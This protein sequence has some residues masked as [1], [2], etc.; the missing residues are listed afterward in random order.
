[1]LG[2]PVL[3]NPLRQDL[4]LSPVGLWENASPASVMHVFP[5]C[6]SDPPGK[7]RDPGVLSLIRLPLWTGD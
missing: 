2:D 1:M 5:P 3:Q 7:D 6:D 4:T